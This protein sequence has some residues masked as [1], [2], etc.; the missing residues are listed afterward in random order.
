[1]LDGIREHEIKY[2]NGIWTR[3]I[4]SI[5][6]PD[7]PSFDYT[8]DDP[9]RWTDQLTKYIADTKE[10]WLRHYQPKEPD[11]II[12]VGAG[13]G[14]DTFTFSRAVGEAGRVI[15][16]EAHPL[17]FAMLKNFCRL[18]H[19]TNVIPLHLALMDKAGTVHIL[20]GPSTWQENAVHFHGDSG[21]PVPADTLD[22]VCDRLG[23]DQ[24]D[25][26]KMNIE[27]AER[28]ALRGIERVITKIGQICVACHDFRA[29]L[30]HG[31]QFRTRNFVE[32]FL[33]GQGFTVVS[34]PDD[35]RDYVRDH[36]FGL[37]DA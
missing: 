3:R 14:E 6:L 33:T 5:Y 25:F 20:E 36:L 32:Q 10:F 9:S 30:G 18:N 28:F 26:L 16:I 8:Y 37:R 2:V 29:D 24:V 11:V 15:A 35:P 4:G 34:R 12:D 7:G 27:G 23:I 19:L 1:M 21:V 17:S 13:R 31:E 22:A